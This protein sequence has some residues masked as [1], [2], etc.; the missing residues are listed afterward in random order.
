M[1]RKELFELWAKA[2]SLDVDTKV[3]DGWDREKY[4]PFIQAMWEGW[5]AAMDEGMKL[6]LMDKAVAPKTDYQRHYNLGIDVTAK[7]FT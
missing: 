6:V 4:L 1:N 5:D 3:P 7:R 2:R